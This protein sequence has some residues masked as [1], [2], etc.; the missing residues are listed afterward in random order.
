MTWTGSCG[1]AVTGSSATQTYAELGISRLMPRP[2]LCRCGRRE[3]WSAGWLLSGLGITRRVVGWSEAV[4]EREQGVGRAVASGAGVRRPD[5][6][7]GLFFDAHVGVQVDLGG[8]GVFVAEPQ[9]DNRSVDAGFQQCHGGGVP[10]R[11][12]GDVLV[13]DRR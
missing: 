5:A 4:E 9:G 10:E 12:R 3:S 1:N 11:V 8:L 7:E 6:G 2:G 13:L